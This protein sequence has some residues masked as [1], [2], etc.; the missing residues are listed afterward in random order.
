MTSHYELVQGKLDSETYMAVGDDPA[1][2]A[3]VSE[4]FSDDADAVLLKKEALI[5]ASKRSKA[6][7]F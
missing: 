4:S 3:F 1:M 5:S 7:L 6:N 2:Q